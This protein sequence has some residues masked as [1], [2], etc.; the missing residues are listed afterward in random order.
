M[1]YGKL[2]EGVLRERELIASGEG[3]W[4]MGA[5]LTKKRTGLPVDV[6]LDDIC[7]Y[8]NTCHWKRI[9][10]QSEKGGS[11]DTNSYAV[12]TIS[13]VPKIIGKHKL[14]GKEVRQIKEWILRNKEAL[15]QLSDAEIEFADFLE[16]MR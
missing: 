14:S 7:M 9:K 15:E 2:L 5:R 3:I 10:F 6:Y 8:K 11:T 1:D 12:M 4:S 13:D 16:V